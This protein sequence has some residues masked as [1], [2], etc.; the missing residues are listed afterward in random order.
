MSTHIQTLLDDRTSAIEALKKAN[1]HLS[2]LNLNMSRKKCEK[3][4]RQQMVDGGRE[5]LRTAFENLP[6]ALF[7]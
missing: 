3:Q 2:K 5:V 4:I 7:N 6:C 1:S